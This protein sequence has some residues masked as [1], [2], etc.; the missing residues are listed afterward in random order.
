[1]PD[2]L[3]Q[4]TVLLTGPQ[5]TPYENGLWKLHLRIP[6]DYPKNPP[7]AAFKTKIYHPN[8][9]DSTGSV[10]LDTL[11]R[12]WQPQLTLRDILITI[13]CLLINPNPDSALNAEAGKLIQE[14]FDAFARKAKLMTSIHATVPMDMKGAITEARTRGEEKLQTRANPAPAANDEQS[15]DEDEDEA[16]AS[17]ENDPSISPSPVSPP[18]S[19]PIRRNTVL[20]KRPLSDLPTPLDEEQ[21][22]LSASE[23]NIAAN[24]PNL[25]SELST[26]SFG[27]PTITPTSSSISS[28]PAS[29]SR[30]QGSTLGE[31][32]RSLNADSVI[33]TSFTFTGIPTS[34]NSE[35]TQTPSAKR[36]CS[37]EGKENVSDGQDTI[38]KSNGLSERSMTST[39]SLQMASVVGLGVRNVPM[40]DNKPKIS[41]TGPKGKPRVGLRRL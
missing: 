12:D 26:L 16:S 3:T 7:K 32:V 14:D 39:A 6:L 4:L 40:K 17:K 37:R 15:D 21:S 25:S 34:S 38:N 13:S 8:V 11:K 24:T 19:M 29:S 33:P 35:P 41:T 36:V 1:M 22:S 5:G 28:F 30:L 9:E 20:G 2:D 18:T 10:C 31:R 27:N 23:R